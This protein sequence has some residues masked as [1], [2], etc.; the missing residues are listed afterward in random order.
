MKLYNT[1][2]GIVI[3]Q[4]EKFYLV[5][6]YWNNFINDDA[7]LQKAT[8]AIASATVVDKSA[9]TNLLLVIMVLYAYVKTAPG[10]YQSRS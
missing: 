6:E 2:N 5:K 1:T 9:I 7:V 3:E 4:N 8:A 10:M